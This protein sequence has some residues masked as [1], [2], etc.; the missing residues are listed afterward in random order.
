M[1][2]FYLVCI[3]NTVAVKRVK[4]KILTMFG[5]DWNNFIKMMIISY[6]KKMACSRAP[7]PCGLMRHLLD[8]EV[9]GSNL[10]EGI[11]SFGDDC[12]KRRRLDN[13]KNR[14]R[15]RGVSLPP[16]PVEYNNNGSVEYNNNGSIEYNNNEKKEEILIINF[17]WRHLSLIVTN[18]IYDWFVKYWS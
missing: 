11:Y 17:M 15:M 1:N 7:W 3:Y 5:L 2:C 12:K 9:V 10:G 4:H 13:W 14:R 18:K 16:P 6:F 8:R